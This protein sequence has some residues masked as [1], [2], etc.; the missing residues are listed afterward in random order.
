MSDG[1]EV[2][3]KVLI[4]ADNDAINR[5]DDDEISTTCPSESEASPRTT[6]CSSEVESS[7]PSSGESTND[8]LRKLKQKLR[9]KTDRDRQA[10]LRLQHE[11]LVRGE[12]AIQQKLQRE[13]LERSQQDA[14]ARRLQAE[15]A[16]ERGHIVAAGQEKDDIKERMAG[17]DRQQGELCRAMQQKEGTRAS[18]Q[19]DLHREQQ[20]LAER[21]RAEQERQRRIREEQERRYR[22]EQRRLYERHYTRCIGG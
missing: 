22:E 15:V 7:H 18:L 21:Q 11:D 10:W 5:R 4:D 19:V 2:L 6:R 17:R 3:S 14:N 1:R 20:A 12:R 8:A 9:A 13:V 16:H